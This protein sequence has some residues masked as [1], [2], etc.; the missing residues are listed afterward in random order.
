MY[1]MR[2][3]ATTVPL[4]MS[5]IGPKTVISMALKTIR[6]RQRAVALCLQGTKVCTHISS[7]DPRKLSKICKIYHF[8]GAQRFLFPKLKMSSADRDCK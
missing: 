5:C 2:S 1:T 6:C 8:S 3:L 4:H 7:L